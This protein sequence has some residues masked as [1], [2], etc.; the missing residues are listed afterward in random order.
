MM[1]GVSS[2]Y[3]CCC[4]GVL[5]VQEASDRLASTETALLCA[6]LQLLCAGSIRC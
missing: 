1:H 5:V 3:H 2:Q 4:S 6:L